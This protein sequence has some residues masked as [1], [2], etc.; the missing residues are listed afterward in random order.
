M[1]PGYHQGQRSG[2]RCRWILDA[3]SP[4]EPAR[5][6]FLPHWRVGLTKAR[7]ASFTAALDAFEQ[8]AN[9]AQLVEDAFLGVVLVFAL[10]LLVVVAAFL[11]LVVFALAL[12][13]ALGV[14]FA[15]V[16]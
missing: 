16:L 1:V 5:D 2:S 14:V 13:L 4:G 10:G 7:R 12:V 8:L 6:S 9:L 3:R 11:V 15:L